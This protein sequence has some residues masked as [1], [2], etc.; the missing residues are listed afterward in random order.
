MEIQSAQDPVSL[1]TSIGEEDDSH[2]GDLY[3]MM[4]VQLHMIQSS[5]IIKSE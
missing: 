5:Y 3:K 4:I 1:E 2:L